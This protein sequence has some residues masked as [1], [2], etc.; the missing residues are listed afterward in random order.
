M[1]TD[2]RKLAKDND[3]T[4]VYRKCKNENR[5]SLYL[6]DKKKQT[7]YIVGWGV[8]N[9]CKYTNLETVCLSAKKYINWYSKLK[10]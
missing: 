6:Y 5:G 4:V 1:L 10:Y 2:L 9:L 8:N 3:I 7:N